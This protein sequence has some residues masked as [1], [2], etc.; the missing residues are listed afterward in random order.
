M[1]M[2]KT[3]IRVKLIAGLSPAETL[4]QTN[5]E[6]CVQNPENLF[7]T[8]FLAVLDPVGGELCYANAGHTYPMLLKE[9]P[10]FLIPESGIVLDMFEDAGIENH[11][12][13]LTPGEGIL[14]YTDGV[15]EAVNPER[16]FFGEQR[17]LEALKEYRNDVENVESVILRVSRVVHDFCAG[18]EP[19]DDMAVLAL[20]RK[21][22]KRGWRKIPVALSSFDEIKKALFAVI[23]ETPEARRALLACDEMLTNIVHYSKATNLSFL[24]D[25]QND[26]LRVAFSDDGIP[27]DPTAVP[28]EEKEFD[29]LDSGGMGLSLIRQ[30]ASSAHYEWKNDRNIL[31]LFFSLQEGPDSSQYH[32]RNLTES[33]TE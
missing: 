14:L 30:T 13:T 20:I 28:L 33:K 6:L 31:S 1:A 3:V 29:V 2:I 18:S 23:G 9:E 8:A 16:R 10:E 12:I 15:T 24:C 25:K 17:L 26:R 32:D 11:T 5:D 27:F 21:E 19:F 22:I 4:N 7:V